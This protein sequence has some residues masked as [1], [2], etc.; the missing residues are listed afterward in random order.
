MALS[1]RRLFFALWPDENVRRGLAQCIVSTVKNIRRNQ[2]GLA[3]YLPED[4]H[5][6]L[7]FIGTVSESYR[8]CLSQ[9]AR[10]VA[11]RKDIEPFS[12]EIDCLGYFEH[13]KVL[14]AGAQSFP[15]SLAQLREALVKAL[16]GCGYG[17]E[18]RA[19][20]PHVTLMRKAGPPQ[21]LQPFTPVPWKV[22][23]F[24]LA[25]SLPVTEGRRYRVIEE[26]E[27]V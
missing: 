15:A 17:V 24:C 7:A 23:G 12:L 1:G 11:E 6:T 26:F 9:A 3:P 20:K 13:G 22:N 16:A 2:P 19:F 21:S 18:S 8:A 5:L 25:E 10:R 4:L 14:W 27:F